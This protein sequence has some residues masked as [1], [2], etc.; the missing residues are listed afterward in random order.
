MNRITDSKFV[1]CSKFKLLMIKKLLLPLYV[2]L[3]KSLLRHKN[4][5]N[6]MKILDS[7]STFRVGKQIHSIKRYFSLRSE[8]NSLNNLN[9]L[10][11]N[12]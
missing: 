1:Y 3:Y 7:K 10:N 11:E 6:S 12:T 2:K 4:I 5:D 9:R 8:E